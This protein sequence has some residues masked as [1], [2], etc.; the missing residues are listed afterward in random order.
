MAKSYDFECV[1]KK[2]GTKKKLSKCI[3]KT[4]TIFQKN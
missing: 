1:G 4:L 3:Y 2:Q